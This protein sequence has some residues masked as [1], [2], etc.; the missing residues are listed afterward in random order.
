MSKKV[1]LTVNGSRFDIELEEAFAKYLTKQ[2]S[3]DFNTEGNN[4]AKTLLYAYVRKNAELFR[5]EEEIVSLLHQLET[6]S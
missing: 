1:S 2:M 4:D 5:Q 3:Q 6:L